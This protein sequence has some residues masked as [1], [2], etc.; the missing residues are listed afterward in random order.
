[1]TLLCK[2]TRC[3]LRL[4]SPK[5]PV[6]VDSRGKLHC[7]TEGCSRTRVVREGEKIEVHDLALI[8]ISRSGERIDF[9]CVTNQP[10]QSKV[11]Q[12]QL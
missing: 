11:W 12:T 10:K 9:S 5:V 1:M 3:L 8:E 2:E 4:A 7:L 6:A